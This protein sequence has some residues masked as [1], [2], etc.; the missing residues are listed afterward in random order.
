[1]IDLSR[2]ARPESD[3]ALLSPLVCLGLLLLPGPAL[4]AADQ[5]QW[6]AAWTR[7]LV[8]PERNLPASF[9]PATGRNVRWVAR[10]G[11]ESY[12]TPVVAKGRVFIGTNNQEPRDPKRTGDRGV[13]QC[14]SEKDGSL[15]W[16]WAVPK[17]DEDPYFDWPR[18][19]MCSPP[20][21]EGNRVYLVNNRGQ[22]GCLDLE[23]M[24]N[25]NDGPI[26]DEGVRLARPGEEVVEAGPLDADVLWLFDLTEGAG[27][28]SHDSAHSSILIDGP[29]L[30]LN[31]ST[32]VDNTHKKIRTPEAPSL[33]VIEKAT[34]RYVA[35]DGEPI[36]PR[37]FHCTWSSP[38]LAEVHG[39]R[40]IFFAAGN[41]SLYAFEPLATNAPPAAELVRLPKVW[42]HDFDPA[43]PKEDVHRFNGN[44]R[45]SP[46]NF[47]GM[48]VFHEG[49]IY[50][51][52]GG[53]MYWGKTEAWLKCVDAANGSERWAYP[54]VKHTIGTPAIHDGLAY[55]TDIGRTLHC[56]D[57]QTG[58]PLWTHQFRGD[59]WASP[60]VA[61]GKVYVGTRRGDFH[62]FAAGRE[63]R[64]LSEVDLDDPISATAVA[65]NGVLYVTTM[66]RLYALA[67]VE[68]R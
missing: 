52:G 56:V 60:L 49:R 8:S 42:E 53:D 63:K 35:R 13:L 44:R 57:A 39:R 2:F 16:Q 14:L 41:G 48:P 55:I 59:F 21:I 1:M 40:L 32:G 24:A 26:R 25:G 20:T 67:G 36:A 22:V 51:A 64:L 31:T 62:V 12:A 11:T 54:L 45:E 27:I 28:W 30:Y 17:R 46:S 10:L 68:E 19:G 65:A 33:V 66:T 18:S 6:G 58:Q 61:D 38:A 29:Y 50:L 5:P 23:G 3:R 9:D 7:N 15:L 43:G 34:G 37:I 4:F 47:Y